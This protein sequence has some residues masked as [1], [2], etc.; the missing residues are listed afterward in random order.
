MELYGD[1]FLET[2]QSFIA[3]RTGASK[4]AQKGDTH[5]ITLEL[6]K[7]G[8]SVEAIAEQ[9]G[10]GVATI[11]AHIAHLAEQGENINLK[12]HILK[13]DEERIREAINIIGNTTA[14]KP[15]FDHM[16]GEIEYHKIRLMLSL[17]KIE[18]S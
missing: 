1:E 3:Q 17:I 8:M 11:W 4:K 7:Q 10:L 2:I 18:N 16:N 5:K 12:Q 15:I 13:E 6:Y 14:M 9:R